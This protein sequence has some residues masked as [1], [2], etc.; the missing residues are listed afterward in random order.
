M[1]DSSENI[2]NMDAT[3][4]ATLRLI[5]THLVASLVLTLSINFNEK[6]Y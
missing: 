6:V 4:Q 2:Q 5:K 1:V 3:Q